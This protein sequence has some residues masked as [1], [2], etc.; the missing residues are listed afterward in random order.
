MLGGVCGGLG[1]YFNVN[2]A[3]YRVAFVVLALLGGAG[4]LI[5]GACL[6]VIPGEGERESIAS[7]ALRNHRRRPALLVGLA[8]VAF[9]GI[10][11]FSRVSFHVDNDLVWLVV[12]VVGAGIMMSEWR[13]SQPRVSSASASTDPPAGAPTVAPSVASPVAT[14]TASPPASRPGP[15]P[16]LLALGGL[17]VAGGILGLLAATGVDIPWAVTLGAAAVAVGVGVVVGAVNRRRVGALALLGILLALAAVLAGTIH[18]HLDDGIGDRSYVPASTAGLRSDYRLGVGHLE[19]DLSKLALGRVPTHVRA[20]LGVGGL[21]VVVPP[22][23]RVHVVGHADWGEV[24]LLGRDD[25]GHDVTTTVGPA[26]ALLV[27][28]ADVGAGRIEV[29]RA[30]R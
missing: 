30:V 13:R 22:G 27:V 29:I 6:L 1:E 23:V 26:D 14:P 20:H 7:E 16:F 5:Y 25:N 10:A 19:I 28:D 17:V 18:L 2:P 11:L 3:F 15:S 12:L 4:I 24:D 9:A 21:R 8:L